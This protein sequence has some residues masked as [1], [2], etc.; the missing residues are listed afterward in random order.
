MQ[1]I[2]QFPKF[3]ECG[4]RSQ[5]RSDAYAAIFRGISDPRWKP[6]NGAVGQL[7]ENILSARELRPS[8]D[9]KSLTIQ[10]VKWVVNSNGL[11]TMGIMFL[12][13]A[14]RARVIWLKPSAKPRS[15]KATR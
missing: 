8:F 1:T 9:A 11:W 14:A 2:Q 15:C 12:A 5:R 4:H 6:A 10:R 13:R 7:A 3:G